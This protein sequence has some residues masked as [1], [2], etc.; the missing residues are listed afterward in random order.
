M[1]RDWVLPRAGP[2]RLHALGASLQG[3]VRESSHPARPPRRAAQRWP[4]L[5]GPGRETVVA[6]A[7]P[8]PHH[9]GWLP[10]RTPNRP[11]LASSR[12]WR[13]PAGRRGA[14]GAAAGDR[15][16]R[17]V[18]SAP[19][20][21]DDRGHLARTAG[22]ASPAGR[23]ELR[24][25]CLRAGARQRAQGGPASRGRGS[26]ADGFAAGPDTSVESWGAM[27]A[28]VVTVLP[29]SEEG[30]ISD[31]GPIAKAAEGALRAKGAPGTATESRGSVCPR[32]PPPTTSS[33]GRSAT[34]P[35]LQPLSRC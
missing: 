31:M 5:S 22:P 21:D 4:G 11:L 29:P 25:R 9:A 24:A 27:A 14:T 17:P 32:P 12:R 35:P 15:R 30:R 20:G 19:L 6:G 28:H 18:Q 26:G 3:M 2:S 16:V 13:S 8:T 34:P 1:C 10:S 23:Q 7:P 33:S